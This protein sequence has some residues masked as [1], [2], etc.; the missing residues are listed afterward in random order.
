[1]NVPPGKT[2]LNQKGLTMSD[3]T[4]SIPR[5]T[6]QTQYHTLQRLR[7]KLKCHLET[8]PQRVGYS[9]RSPVY[10]ASLTT[11]Q[12]QKLR[13]PVCEGDR[14]ASVAFNKAYLCEFDKKGEVI[15]LLAKGHLNEVVRLDM[16]R[17]ELTM[18]K[19]LYGELFPQPVKTM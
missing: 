16:K 4:L 10:K 9:R 14:M 18:T 17:Y 1:M 2:C 5:V 13:V 11:L 8:N 12:C 7:R 19:R 6:C 3:I 15:Y